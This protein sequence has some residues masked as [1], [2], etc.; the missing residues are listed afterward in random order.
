MKLFIIK[1][2]W[3]V[4]FLI[5]FIL[6]VSHSFKVT[7]L[8]VDSTSILLLLVMLISPFVAA[9]KK[10]KFGDFEAEIDPKEIQRIKSE[11][12]KNIVFPSQEEGEEH[13]EENK[14]TISIREIAKSDTVLALAKIRI[15]IEKALQLIAKISS[16]DSS[17]RTLGY[18]VKKLSDQEIIT[19]GVAHSLREVIGI[20]NRAIHGEALSE[21]SAETIIDLGIELID[22]LYWLYKNQAVTSPIISEDIINPGEV[23]QYIEEKRYRLTSVIPL[24]KNPKK[25]VRELTQEQLNEVLEHY[26][27]YAEFIVE[28]TEI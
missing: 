13:P 10:I 28:L 20:C 17:R 14:T 25:V 22:D 4:T 27:E 2:L 16:V 12:D 21:D 23:L 9:I 11:A 5:A 8:S 3:W 26:N 6:L 15:E 24:V 7:S 19:T 1:N 18:L